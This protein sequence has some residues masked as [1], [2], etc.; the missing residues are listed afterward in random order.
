MKPA[1]RW[2]LALVAFVA[3]FAPAAAAR[4]VGVGSR[5]EHLAPVF[6]DAVDAVIGASPR[7]PPRPIRH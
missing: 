7:R 3:T 2:L 5:G 4:E 6:D 1:L